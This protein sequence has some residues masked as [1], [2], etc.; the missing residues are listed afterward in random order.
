MMRVVIT[1]Y[2]EE[3]VAHSIRFLKAAEA[4]PESRALLE[5]YGYSAEE[6]ERG[7]QLVA[8]AARS[9]EWERSGR[10]YNFL[11]P[12]PERRV[13]EARAWYAETRRR[14]VQSC[15]KHAEEAAGWVGNGAA[16]AWSIRKKLTLGTLAALPHLARAVSLAEWRAHRDELR[17]DIERAHAPRPADAPP[18][19]DTVLVE[20]GGWYERWR[21]LAHR[22]MRGRPDLL[23]PYG[24]VAG[25]APPRLRG[26]EARLKY[27]EGAAGTLNG[28]PVVEDD[29]EDIL[30]ADEH[31]KTGMN[32]VAKNGKAERGKALPIVR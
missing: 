29:D 24:L 17:S 18:P 27:G 31:P 1:K 13:E 30:A 2:D 4:N 11:A 32:G 23:A 20:L 21:L 19:K 7:K 3:L 22:V 25:K 9:F 16:S 28:A 14:H 12:T 8:D 26:K 15:I 10:A 6:H 5:K